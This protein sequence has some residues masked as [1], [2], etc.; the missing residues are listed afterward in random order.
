M[1]KAGKNTLYVSDK[2]CFPWLL[3]LLSQ[4]LTVLKT[5]GLEFSPLAQVADLSFV[6]AFELQYWRLPTRESKMKSL[7]NSLSITKCF[8]LTAR[9]ARPVHAWPSLPPLP[10]IRV[11]MVS[12]DPPWYPPQ[13]HAPLGPEIP[14]ELQICEGTPCQTPSVVPPKLSTGLA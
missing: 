4:N 13:I 2:L 6:H 5:H 10:Q 12:Q 7:K 8:H 14:A 1:N 9:I 3:P 11:L